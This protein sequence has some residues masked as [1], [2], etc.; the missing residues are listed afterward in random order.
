MYSIDIHIKNNLGIEY[1]LKTYI[2]YP[3]CKTTR[4]IEFTIQM[5]SQF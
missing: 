1:H 2:V 3:M 5:Q 4:A